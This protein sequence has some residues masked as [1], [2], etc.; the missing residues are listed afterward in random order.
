MVTDARHG[1]NRTALIIVL[2]C[3]SCAR[4]KNPP[5]TIFAAASLQTVMPALQAAFTAEH[6]SVEFAC[7]YAGSQQ[8]V[9]QL[10]HG[11]PA[12]VIAS[13]DLAALQPLVK[14]GLI[15]P[16]QIFAV[17][18]PVIIVQGAARQQVTSLAQLPSV[19]RLIIGAPEVP[20][21][22]YTLQILDKATPTLGP[23]FRA[24]VEAKVVSRELT[25]RQVLARVLSGEAE[26]GIVYRTDV[27][28]QALQKLAVVEIDPAFNV[29]AE[30]PMAVVRH[31]PPSAL[32]REFISFVQGP[33]GQAVLRKAGFALPEGAVRQ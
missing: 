12:D 21:G 28:A 25:V 20:I 24:Q 26:A 1:V 16:P 7:N 11:A 33:A 4:Q 6:P 9:T 29:I 15:E 19:S 23:Q 2:I 22:R 5:V 10:T 8:L 3:A 30:Y 31:E 13:A 32:A 18:Q 27:D 17:N 14:D